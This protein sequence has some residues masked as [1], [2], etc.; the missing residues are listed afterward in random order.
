M[1]D[2]QT[3]PDWWH[4]QVRNRIIKERRKEREIE[5]LNRR[6]ISKLKGR[7]F[8]EIPIL[9]EKSLICDFPFHNERRLTMKSDLCDFRSL[10]IQEGDTNLAWKYNH[11]VKGFLGADYWKSLK[12]CSL[13]YVIKFW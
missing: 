8:K 3:M 2:L 7:L 5:V 6:R 11:L 1:A 13:D 12:D 9:S 10:L 4:E